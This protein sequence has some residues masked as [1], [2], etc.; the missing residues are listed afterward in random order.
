MCSK[1]CLS[2]WLAI[3]WQ[4]YSWGSIQNIF[5]VIDGWPGW[6]ANPHTKNFK[7]FKFPKNIYHHWWL[8]CLFSTYYSW[9]D[10]TWVIF[11]FLA[12]LYI[13]ERLYPKHKFCYCFLILA[14]KF[15]KVFN[16]W[17]Y[18]VDLSDWWKLDSC[19]L[20]VFKLYV[21]Q[22]LFIWLTCHNFEREKIW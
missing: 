10:L 1:H 20:L 9:R 21:S 3:I 19:E 5:V 2:H 4:L 22:T 18:V 14:N 7:R 16:F 6:F 11:H 15:I 8:A 12:F 17:K 13:F